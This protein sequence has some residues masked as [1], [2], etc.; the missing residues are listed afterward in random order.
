MLR[1]WFRDITDHLFTCA[2]SSGGGFLP[3]S[4][5]GHRWSKNAE[6]ENK[7]IRNIQES[8]QGLKPFYFSESF[9]GSAEAVPLLQNVAPIE[10]FRKVCAACAR[11]PARVSGGPT[12]LG[13]SF[14]T[15]FPGL[16]C[17]CPGLFS[18]AP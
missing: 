3:A 7:H 17:A 12:G 2:D 8:L 15:A 4:S 14:G 5:C 1:L 16:R 11:C 6:A 13:N 10:V 9:I 18:M